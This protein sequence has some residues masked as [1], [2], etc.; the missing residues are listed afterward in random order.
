MVNSKIGGVV[1]TTPLKSVKGFVWADQRRCD[2]SD[3]SVTSSAWEY[4]MVRSGKKEKRETMETDKYLTLISET[5][6]V[7]NFTVRFTDALT[8]GEDWEVALVQAY[9]PHRDSHFQESFKKYF[10]NNKAIGE[11]V[12]HYNTSPTATSS[13][14]TSSTVRIN[15]IVD[16]INK[17]TT[18]LDV[19]KMIYTVAWNKIIHD[20]KT[21]ASVTAAYPKDDK[22]NVLHQILEETAYGVTLKG[23]AVKGGRFTLDKTLAQ[24]IGVMNVAGTGLGSGVH[25]RI[26]D[27][28]NIKRTS[29]FTYNND[30]INLYSSVDWV[31]TLHTTWSTRYIPTEVYRH[32]DINC[33]LIVPQ[34]VNNDDTNYILY[35][36]EIPGNGGLVIPHQRIYVKLRST[37]FR[38]IQI[39]ITDHETGQID[40]TLPFEKTRVI[41]HVRNKKPSQTV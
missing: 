20:F 37:S 1:K 13:T 25:Y 17:G 3:K 16:G 18:K 11:L 36:A 7:N 9:L 22:G 31:F 2:W 40:Q 8:F 19:L 15:D 39:W 33:S 32:V 30:E 26:R 35:H 10:P 14:S 12:V 28:E 4:I 24:M 41:L 27:N 6:N 21:D 23:Y 29:A 34:Q 38:S 5:S